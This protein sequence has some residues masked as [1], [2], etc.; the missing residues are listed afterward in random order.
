[1]HQPGS[2]CVSV[3][4]KRVPR[5]TGKTHM[6]TYWRQIGVKGIR[7]SEHLGMFCIDLTYSMRYIIGAYQQKQ[8]QSYYSSNTSNFSKNKEDFLPSK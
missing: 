2:H 7:E 4:G 6:L 5:N 8:F 3:L 1:M